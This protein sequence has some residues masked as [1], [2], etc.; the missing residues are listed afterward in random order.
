M[1]VSDL[2]NQLHNIS[3]PI[4]IHHAQGDRST[5]S[6][7]SIRL[8]EALSSTSKAAELLLYDADEHFFAEE[9]RERAADCDAKFFLNRWFRPYGC[10]SMYSEV[11]AFVKKEH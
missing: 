6:D 2:G 10:K 1:D 8:A 4:L 5:A 9:L 3:I 7:N 11:I